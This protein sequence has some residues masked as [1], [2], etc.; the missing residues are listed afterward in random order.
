[1]PTLE[2]ILRTSPPHVGVVP[3][4]AALS[5]LVPLTAE[6][7]SVSAAGGSGHTVMGSSEKLWWRSKDCPQSV[8]RYW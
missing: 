1:M 3:L 2:K 8:Q 5:A 7:S 6:L 4:A